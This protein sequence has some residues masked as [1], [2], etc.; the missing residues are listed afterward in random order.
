MKCKVNGPA[1]AVNS[2]V[3]RDRERKSCSSSD[4]ERRSAGIIKTTL[5]VAPRLNV[6]FLKSDEESETRD[7]SFSIFKTDFFQYICCEYQS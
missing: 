2:K 6:F 1:Y 7:F 5:F 3:I 4:K